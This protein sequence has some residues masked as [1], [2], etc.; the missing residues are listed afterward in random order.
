VVQLQIFK[1]SLR[2]ALGVNLPVLPLSLFV[3]GVLVVVEVEVMV[4]RAVAV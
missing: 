4:D 2:L 3:Y 1:N